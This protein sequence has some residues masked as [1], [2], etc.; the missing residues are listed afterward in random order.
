M[1]IIKKFTPVNLS[2]I[3]SGRFSQVYWKVEG[4]LFP[5][6]LQDEVQKIENNN[7]LL[8]GV[9]ESGVGADWDNTGGWSGYDFSNYKYPS[10]P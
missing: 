10:A 5:P 1:Y 3:C 7:P 9:G 2:F 4:K 6:P 8:G